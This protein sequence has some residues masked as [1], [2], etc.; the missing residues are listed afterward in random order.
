MSRWL[1]PEG[2]VSYDPRQLQ[3]P[4]TGGRLFVLGSALAIAWLML[5]SS[6]LAG[7]AVGSSGSSAVPTTSPDTSPGGH[8]ATGSSASRDS[9][10]ACGLTPSE[11]AH[12]LTAAN[13]P[14][15]AGFID[16]T[17]SV[18]KD[19]LAAGLPASA[20]HLPY[21][22]S[23]PDQTI[24]GM[25]ETGVQI[26][27]DCPENNA[28]DPA[29]APAGVAYDGQSFRGTSVVNDP[30]IDT[31]SVLGV[32]T[33]QSSNNFYPDSATPTL[34]GAQL[35]AVLA[36]VTILGHR[37]YD[38]WVQNVISYDSHNDTLSFVDDT[39]NFT[40]GSSEMQ[41]S[42]L[43]SW[44][45]NGSDYTGVW[46]AF[47]QTYYAPPPF[48]ASV[49]VNSS[50]NAAGDQILWYNY[51]LVAQGRTHSASY[52]DL[53]FRTQVP[54][55]PKTV[56]PPSFEASAT[57]THEVNEGYEFDS[58]IGADD[59]SNQLILGANATEQLKY[60]S[61][62]DCTPTSFQYADVP[63]AVN[64]GSQ[65]GEQTVGVSVNFVGTTAFLSAGP[66][67]LHGLWNYTGASGTY[68]GNVRV[69]NHI[70]VSG[71]PLPLTE[72]PYVF[73]FFEDT[74]FR[75]E[76]FQWSADTPSW[77][78]MPGTYQYE[79][80]LA[81]YR[82]Q[83]GTLTVGNST[84][85]LTARLPY[86]IAT[87][88]YTPLWAFDNGQVAGISSSGNGTL[89]D[90][91][92]LF[93]NPTSGCSACGLATNGSLSPVFFSSND[94]AFKTFA[95][96]FLSGTSAYVDVNAPPSFLVSGAIGGAS[97]F[98]LNFQFYRTSHVTLSNASA[99]RGW[100]AQEE[101]GFYVDVPASQN[102]APQGD[103]YVWDSSHDLIMSDRFVAEQPVS[104]GYVSPDQLVLYGG[105]DNVV[106]GNTFQ[107]PI[108]VPLGRTYGGLGV[109]ESGD[110]IFNNNF[111]IDNPV[112]YLPFNF[113]NVADCLPQC[114]ERDLNDSAFYN[115]PQNSWN[116]TPQAAAAVSDTVNGFALSGN[117]LGS[118]YTVY[119]G[120]P[121][122]SEQGGNY[123]WN[124]GR[125]PNNHSSIPY[126]DRF[127]YSD[128]SEIY[129]LGCG[130]IQAPGAPCGTA[131]PVVGAYEDGI[132][133]GGDS[134][135]IVRV[136][137]R[138]ILAPSIETHSGDPGQTLGAVLPPAQPAA[139]WATAAQTA[140]YSPGETRVR[141]PGRVRIVV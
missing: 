99:I 37:G 129:P 116:V 104:S 86:S 24:G 64:F 133:W 78:L 30:T 135:P 83:T 132:P 91:Y 34:W 71:S 68:S 141:S 73:V 50:V 52:D 111:S 117:I 67:I 69:L 120:G 2:A 87:G 55:T 101:I 85:T 46:V 28:S 93:N 107:D 113:P 22:G 18:A 42:S 41:P 53:V 103:V 97:S 100:P 38:F 102:P 81:D 127:L 110:L 89:A 123:F 59:G 112:L 31:N 95:G 80:M 70:R 17:Q 19:A 13:D 121:N 20:L 6:P 115:H 27:A 82:E 98:Y 119:G 9:D 61:L 125:S 92:V 66:L 139:S 7:A 122:S 39:W 33:V 51:S 65:T 140:A 26:A 5:V 1:P 16:H 124:Y 138:G 90:Q 128:W 63:A 130:T 94:Y 108:G 60:C 8:G 11:Q 4:V 79:I 54:G 109:A 126:V 72:Q 74:A 84:A 43:V 12:E 49:Y 131:P 47:S 45:P 118:G 56:H 137:V 36:N 14:A 58:F 15:W 25:P 134:A 114:Y 62:P 136:P 88:V 44:S 29:P 35:N 40:T 48:T 96:V 105:S 3:G 77:Y 75:Y 106:W 32:L 57:T 23:V 10:A 21:A 76:G